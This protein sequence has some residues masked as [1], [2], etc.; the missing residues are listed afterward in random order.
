[1]SKIVS[2]NRDNIQL[3][4]VN[5]TVKKQLSYYLEHP[6]YHY[7]SSSIERPAELDHSGILEAHKFEYIAVDGQGRF[8][9]YVLGFFPVS[10]NQLW[11]QQLAV[12]KDYIRQGLGRLIYQKT[13]DLLPE[14]RDYDCA[15][16]TCHT[17]NSA[18]LAF[19]KSLGFKEISEIK[20]S[21]HL[22]K[23]HIRS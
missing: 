18:G 21:H 5:D 17:D 16:L 9:G 19:W 12:N 8:L 13:L 7:L 6:F 1:M 2:I 3:M 23:A 4:P 22:M 11:I 15:Y 20:G 10:D 14:L